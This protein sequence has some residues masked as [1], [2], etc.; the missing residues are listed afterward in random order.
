MTLSTLAPFTHPS[1]YPITTTLIALSVAIAYMGLGRLLGFA[2]LKYWHSKN[3]LTLNL[4]G[5]GTTTVADLCKSLIPSCRLNPFIFNGHL[6]T[7]WTQIDDR[8]VPNLLQA[9]H[10]P[11]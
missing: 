3:S 5:G 1:N 9:S 2:K 7:L 8:D 4:K 10:L 6:Q 11:S